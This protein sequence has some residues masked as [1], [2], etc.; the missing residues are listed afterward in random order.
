MVCY[1][2]Q[3]VIQLKHGKM[4]EGCEYIITT[5]SGDEPFK[6]VSENKFETTGHGTEISA[7]IERNKPDIKKN[8]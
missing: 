3:I 8:W 2:F 5:S 1:V 4:G 6:I 7:Y